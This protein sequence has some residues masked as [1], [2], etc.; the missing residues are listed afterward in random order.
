M[1]Q[2]LKPG[3]SE[4]MLI[5]SEWGCYSSHLLPV[6]AIHFRRVVA[7]SNHLERRLLVPNTDQPLQSGYSKG[8]LN[9]SDWGCFLLA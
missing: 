7:H 6:S 2:P 5:N 8:V 4:E 9:N 1:E 3:Y